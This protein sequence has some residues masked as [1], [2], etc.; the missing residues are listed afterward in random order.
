MS[1]ELFR[2]RWQGGR[3]RL[4]VWYTT[5]TD[6]VTG[7]GVWIH[8][9]LIAPSGGGEP[10]A[11]GW[12]ALFPP[13]EKPVLGRYGPEPWVPSEAYACESAKVTPTTLRGKAGPLSWDL[14]SSGGGDPLYTF[15]RWAWRTGL[16][17]A[18]QV[19]PSPTAAFSGTVRCGDRVLDLTAARGGTARIYGHGNAAR[20][21]WLHADLGGDDVCEIVTAV[22]TRR[23]LRHLPPVPL[24]R[25]RFDGKEWP[26]RDPLLASLRMHGTIALPTWTVEGRSGDHL[27]RVNVTLPEAETVT[28]EYQDPDGRV[29][30]C[31]HST[32]ANA[33]ITLLRRENRTWVPFREWTL[34]STAHAEVGLRP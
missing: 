15:P 33:E 22:P 28:V 4:E 21:T 27:I 9:E 1:P 25:L 29:P 31:H 10:L 7:T 18:A 6:P 34:N 32:R 30:L 23:L 5:L 24:L 14:R 3:G 19:V 17:P 26:A 2:S 13:G 20:W 16:L 12:A 11:H 8:H